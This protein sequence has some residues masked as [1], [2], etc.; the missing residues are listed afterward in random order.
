VNRR[1]RR[2]RSREIR[3]LTDRAE[4]LQ[5]R[6]LTAH[7][8]LRC[9][10]ARGEEVVA[11]AHR[12]I[13]AYVDAQAQVVAVDVDSVSDDADD[14]RVL[15]MMVEWGWRGV[16]TVEQARRELDEE[17]ARRSVGKGD[18]ALLFSSVDHTALRLYETAPADL[19]ALSG[20]DLMRAATE[21]LLAEDFA[22]TLMGDP[23]WAEMRG[24]WAKLGWHGASEETFNETYVRVVAH[25]V[26]EFRDG[27]V[28]DTILDELLDRAPP[29]QRERM[30][31]AFAARLQV[32]YDRL[33]PPAVVTPSEAWDA[34][35]EAKV[36]A[37][38]ML[39]LGADEA[40]DTNG[41][42][43]FCGR[44]LSVKWGDPPAEPGNLIHAM[45]T[46]R[47]YDTM[48]ADEFVSAVV[49]RDR[50][51][52]RVADEL[53]SSVE[54]TL[55]D[56][57]VKRLDKIAG[58]W[59]TTRNGAMDRIVRESVQ[60]H[61][62]QGVTVPP[63]AV[64]VD[65][66]RAEALRVVEKTLAEVDPKDRVETLRIW[67]D[68]LKNKMSECSDHDMMRVGRGVWE[69]S[70]ALGWTDEQVRDELSH[71]GTTFVWPDHLILFTAKWAVHA[72][73]RLMTSHTF[74]AALMCSDYQKDVLEGIEEQWDAFLVVVPNGMLVADQFEFSRVLVGTYSF[75]A[76]M[77]LLT[78]GGPAIK[79]PEARTV[80]DEAPTLADLLVS[81]ESNLV[82]ESPTQRCLVMAKRLVAGL[83]LNLQ[84]AGTHKVRKVDARLKS[85]GREAE[86]AHRIVTV[87]APIE[88][89][90]RSSVK[91]YIEHGT[92]DTEKGCRRRGTPTVQWMVRGH[93]RMQAHG[94][95]H[96]LRRKTWI[97]PHWQGHEAALIQT[98]GAKV[99]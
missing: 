8:E 61:M 75:G 90:C 58:R 2:A 19:L 91:E 48:T 45:P 6:L 71:F 40:L 21:R 81:E 86:P 49:D 23:R 20:E 76:R 53:R 35:E 78:T 46:C 72:F 34:G 33:R 97:R 67:R 70:Y 16:R 47:Q 84:D 18:L 9:A 57:D 5:A 11:S 1:E 64:S 68:Q 99:D 60:E 26:A 24:R 55:G 65:K 52:E 37:G 41:H 74:A 17:V 89:D 39:A 31:G 42:C 36:R 4:S 66:L 83:L 14:P 51:R 44:S 28:E 29:E 3:E 15:A 87:G 13:D 82:A 43:P 69:T 95:R 63:G 7:Q 79:L 62:P 93:F 10:R 77:V 80:L 73:Q 12:E 30:M 38:A 94:P 59:G 25:R 88:I 32:E 27:D 54:I 85:K 50:E 92:R 22:K 96:T 56:A 98:R